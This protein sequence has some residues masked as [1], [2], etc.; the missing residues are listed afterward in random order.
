[1]PFHLLKQKKFRLAIDNAYCKEI[2]IN[3]LSAVKI[4]ELLLKQFIQVVE[5]YQKAFTT[6]M[7][8]QQFIIPGNQLEKYKYL[9]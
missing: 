5:H 2:K 8:K 6:Y 9:S 3:N 1:M 7:L 4:I